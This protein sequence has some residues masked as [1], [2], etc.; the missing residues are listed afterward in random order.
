MSLLHRH[1]W[2]EVAR[3]FAPPQGRWVKNAT[4]E[5]GREVTFGFT[6]VELRCDGCGDVTHRRLPGDATGSA[7]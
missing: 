1:H 3:R 5:F 4:E 2:V 6:V 7:R